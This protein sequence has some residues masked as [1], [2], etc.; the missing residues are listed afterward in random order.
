MATVAL[1]YA[2]LGHIARI[3]LMRPIATDIVRSVVCL[4]VWLLGKR[5]S[6]E[7]VAEPIEMPFREG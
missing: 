2:L 4:S 1:H 6:P 5:A 7:T 3:A